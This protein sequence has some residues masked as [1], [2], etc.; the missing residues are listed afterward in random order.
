MQKEHLKKVRK[1]KKGRLKHIQ[2]ITE[3]L[4]GNSVVRVKY[5]SKEGSTQP[6]RE[7]FQGLSGEDM[8]KKFEEYLNVRYNGNLKVEHNSKGSKMDVVIKGI[9]E[10]KARLV[11][12]L[13]KSFD[14]YLG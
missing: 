4:E 1:K 12:N 5:E 13:V 10:G 2:I 11:V 14:R 7:G 3:E 9:E 6:R 8:S